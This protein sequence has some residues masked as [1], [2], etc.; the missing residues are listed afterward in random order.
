M[1]KRLTTSEFIDKC[2]KIH[3][4]TYDYSKVEYVKGNVDVEIICKVH[5]KFLQKAIDHSTGRG[6]KKCKHD[7]HRKSI[8]LTQEKFLQKA[9]N[10]HN[11]FYDYSNAIYIANRFKIEIICPAHGSF[12]QNA[13]NHLTGSGCPECK[14]ITLGKLKRSNTE[15]FIKKSNVTHFNFY[16]YSQVNY[17][18]V[19]NPVKIICPKHG[20]FTQRPNDHLNGKGCSSCS[21]S[22]PELYIE[23]ILKEYSIN[24]IKNDRKLIKPYEIDFYISDKNLGIEYHGNYFHSERNG[25]KDKHYHL[26]KTTKCNTKGVQLIQIFEHE[27]LSNKKL[28]KSKLIDFLD[29]NRFNIKSEKFEVREL[30]DLQAS[31]FTS[32]Y[33]IKTHKTN[34][35]L[36]L[37]YKNRLIQTMGLDK[38][39]NDYHITN[40]CKIHNFKIEKGYDKI[41]QFFKDNYTFENLYMVIDRRWQMDIPLDLE[42][43]KSHKIIDPKC[44][45]FSMKN[46]KK[47]ISTTHEGDVNYDRL[48]DCGYIEYKL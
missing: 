16:D 4:D 28:I 22:Y 31:K 36:G 3:G 32:K 6:C 10:K 1:S 38:K 18:T 33:S 48:W 12:I 19:L 5:G 43:F 46:T 17:T 30:S 40:W 14:K 26:N 39:I 29:K 8:T 47:I 21:Q 34:L 13:C 35:N 37:F 25:E 24:F 15:E 11:N 9:K 41:L 23:K 27:F 2:I 45:Y 7:N 44:H 20:I 42:Y